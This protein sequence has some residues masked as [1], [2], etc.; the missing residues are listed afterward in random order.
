[1]RR[2]LALITL[3]ALLASLLAVPLGTRAAVISL[4]VLR[5]M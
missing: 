2:L 4:L 3:E 5:I 1:M